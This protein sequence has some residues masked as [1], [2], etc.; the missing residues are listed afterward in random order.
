MNQLT[1][2]N[3]NGQLLVDSR[4]VAVMIER[5]HNDLMKAIRNYAEHLT[6]GDFSLG[7][8][9]LPSEYVDKQNQLRPCFLLTRK[10]CDMVA[11]KMTGEKGTLFTATYVTKFEEMEKQISNPFAGMSKELQA[12]FVLDKKIEERTS[13]IENRVFHLEQTKTVDYSQQQVLNSLCKRRVM[14]I[15]GGKQ[16][17][18][19]KQIVFKVFKAAWNEYQEYFAVNSY[20]NTATKDFEKAKEFLQKWTPRGKLLREIEEA[21]GQMNMFDGFKGA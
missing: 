10:G 17:P 8:F 6:Q 11:N 3:Q 12:I 7:E 13:E 21:N 9:F 19:Y 20:R 1:V 15:I 18:A 4:E 2:I 14:E 5:P 16:S